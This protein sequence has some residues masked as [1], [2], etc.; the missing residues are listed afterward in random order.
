MRAAVDDLN[1]YLTGIG[2]T[3][4]AEACSVHSG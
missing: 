3:T 4:V 2:V 1:A